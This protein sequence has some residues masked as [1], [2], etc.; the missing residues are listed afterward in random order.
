MLNARNLAKFS[1]LVGFMGILADSTLAHALL[2][3]NDPYWTYWITKTLLI[4]TVFALGTAWYGFGP[5]RGAVITVVHTFIL[6]IYYWTFS[7]VGLPEKIEWLDPSHVWTTGLP[8]HFMVIYLGYL[9]AWW[10]W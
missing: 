6:S 7:P 10:I 3:E 4:T 2:W 8:I 1:L 9:T 5:A